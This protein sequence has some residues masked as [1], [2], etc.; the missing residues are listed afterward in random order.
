MV[1]FDSTNKTHSN[2]M[3]TSIY[4]ASASPRRRELLDQLG[5]EYRVAPAHIDESAQEGEAA[6]TYVSRLARAK[7]AAVWEAHAAAAPAPVLGAD[8]VVVLEGK[9]LGK[10]A[11]EADGRVMLE[12]LSGRSHQVLTAVAVQ[13]NDVVH[14]AL[15]ESTVRFR[16]LTE[17]ECKRYWAT[18]EPADKAGA[19]A[20]QGKGAMFI[21]RLEGSYSGVMGL[22]LF[23]TAALL[24]R[25]GL[26]L[27]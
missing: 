10:P 18:G 9:V 20:I 12:Q 5:V 13:Q 14:T 23:E 25:F 19:Y 3:H 21:E 11:D 4:L 24:G 7:A 8:T 15:S 22:P 26:S 16:T 17:A 1:T 6:A 27:L 2:L